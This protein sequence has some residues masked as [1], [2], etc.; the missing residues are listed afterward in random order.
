[1]MR[2]LSLS[3]MSVVTV[4]SVSIVPREQ[5]IRTKR[6]SRSE[7]RMCEERTQ[8][9]A[10]QSFA[11]NQVCQHSAV[12]THQTHKILHSVH[13]TEHLTYLYCR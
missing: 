11:A 4:D 9:I 8:V 3:L 1:M 5:D 6:G 2:L 13:R 7:R 10:Q 12:S